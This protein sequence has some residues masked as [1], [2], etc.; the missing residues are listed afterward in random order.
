MVYG[1]ATVESSADGNLT[2][3]VQRTVGGRDV[4]NER[5]GYD[6]ALL[7]AGTSS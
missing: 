1:G 3:T 6:P 4:C 7:M 2:W 5:F